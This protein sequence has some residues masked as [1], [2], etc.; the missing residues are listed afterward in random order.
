MDDGS[1]Q[2]DA[3]SP[4]DAAWN[5]GGDAWAWAASIRARAAWAEHR[6]AWRAK[7]DA[8]DALGLVAAAGGRIVDAYGM[9]DTAAM[10][11]A[12]ESMRRASATFEAAAKAFRRSSGLNEDAA[13]DERM[14]ASLYERGSASKEAALALDRAEKSR[15]NAAEEARVAAAAGAGAAEL[16]QEAG[17]M[18]KSAARWDGGNGGARHKWDGDMAALVR[19]HEA[20]RKDAGVERARSAAILASAVEAE[21]LAARVERLAAEAARH[22]AESAAY[23]RDDPNAREALDAWRDAMAAANR[24]ADEHAAGRMA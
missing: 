1:E 8:D 19:A 24:A 5:A 18:D 11:R 3:A 4:A 20:M 14:A 17:A 2:R 10:G 6:K 21:R 12:A 7:T 9:V 22:M 23:G 13:A 16:A 15:R